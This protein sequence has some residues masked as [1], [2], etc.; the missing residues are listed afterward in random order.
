M[1][2]KKSLHQEDVSSAQITLEHLQ[3]REI[4]SPTDVKEDK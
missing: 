3:T 1:Q 2:D 4:V